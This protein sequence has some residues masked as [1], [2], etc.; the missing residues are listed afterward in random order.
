MKKAALYFLSGSAFCLCATFIAVDPYFFKG[1]DVSFFTLQ[2]RESKE[3]E[4]VFRAPPIPPK[5]DF[6]GENIPLQ[7]PFVRESLE[8]ELTLAVYSIPATALILK[9]APRYK[10]EMMQILRNEGIPEDFFYLMVAESGIRNVT[11]PMGAQGFWQIMEATAKELGLEVNQFVDE[12]D[13]P[14]KATYAAC[15]YLKTAYKRFN[16]WTHVAAS[17]NMGMAG[18]ANS[19]SQQRELNYYD[20]WL[21]S[22]TAR[23]VYRILALKLILNY[24]KTYGYRIQEKQ[25]YQPIPCKTITVTKTVPDLI[26]FAF[27]NGTTYK[28]LKLMNP[29]LKKSSLPVTPGKKYEIAI[30]LKPAAD[31]NPE[32]ND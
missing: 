13:H 4:I 12:R 15:K 17:Y 31:W 24:P 21:N 20:L 5:L 29:W 10:E 27:E 1:G 9:R 32:S 16:N 3:G 11:S 30:P 25:L 2:N 7:D 19:L 22:E 6:A 26:Q 23:Y 8:N 28:E 14:I 18:Y